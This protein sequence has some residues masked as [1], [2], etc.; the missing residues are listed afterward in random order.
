MRRFFTWLL[1]KTILR[2]LKWKIKYDEK[3]TNTKKSH[4]KSY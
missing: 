3:R 1:T 4:K 2:Q